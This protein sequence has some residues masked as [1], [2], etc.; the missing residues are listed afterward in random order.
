[1]V[2]VD[3]DVVVLNVTASPTARLVKA[4]SPFLSMSLDDV[5]AYVVVPELVLIVTLS[6]PTAV[7]VPLIGSV[8][9]APAR[10]AVPP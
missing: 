1:M 2:G 4:A 3:P 10:P 8:R 9:V 6:V 5:T 7:T